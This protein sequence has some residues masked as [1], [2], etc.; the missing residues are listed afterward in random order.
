MRKGA[1]VGLALV[2]ACAS[3][4]AAYAGTGSKSAKPPIHFELITFQLA[5]SDLL[6]EFKAGAD[7]A[8]KKINAKG[9]F[10]GRKVV[11]DT[12]NSQL[13]PSVA[14]A[15]AHS[16]LGNHP[17]A[18]FGCELSWSAAGLAIYAK[19]G[20]PS[21]NCPNTTRSEERRVGKERSW[22]RSSAEWR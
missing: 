7:A 19:A 12:C 14:T 9:G 15:C 8:A 3:G 22:S 20:V 4:V 10:G 18:M 1:L 2:L 16:T 6:T 13:T 21:F 11:I 5:G 17:V